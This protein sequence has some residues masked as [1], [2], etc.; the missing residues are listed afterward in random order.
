MTNW[1]RVLFSSGGGGDDAAWGLTISNTSGSNVANEQLPVGTDSAGN[2]FVMDCAVGGYG[3]SGTGLLV[4]KITPDGALDWERRIHIAGS[5][6]IGNFLVMDGNDPVCICRTFDNL[7]GTSNEPCAIKLSNSNGSTTYYEHYGKSGNAYNMGNN[8][9]L[10]GIQSDGT[11]VIGPLSGSKSQVMVRADGSTG[12]IKSSNGSN[13]ATWSP[14]VSRTNCTVGPNDKIILSG[15]TEHSG[16]PSRRGNVAVFSSDGSTLDWAAGCDFSS[17][18]YSAQGNLAVM[19]SSGNVYHSGRASGSGLIGLYTLKFPNNGGSVSWSDNY[20]EFYPSSPLCRAMITDSTDLFQCGYGGNPNVSISGMW[21]SKSCSTGSWN[22]HYLLRIGTGSGDACWFK[23][24]CLSSTGN[25]VIV[26]GIRYGS[27]YEVI[28]MQ[29]P[30][31]GITAQN[32]GS[33]SHTW[34]VT[35]ASRTNNT[36]PIYNSP[37][38]PSISNEGL[39]DKTDLGLSNNTP[40]GTFTENLTDMTQ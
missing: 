12:A 1:K 30:K 2:I 39:T 14:N 24:I 37:Y 21:S 22:W 36:A 5:S 16:S 4:Y 27:P 20:Y 7:I 10:A 3:Q 34:Q 26:T 8:E 18:S 31:T 11:I 6:L 17:S 40:S 25:S 19:D 23:G 15:A 33:G 28:V 32:Y 38:N 35:N 13:M 9:G 29:V